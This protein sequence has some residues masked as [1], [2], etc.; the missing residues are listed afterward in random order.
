MSAYGRLD[1]V[2]EYIEHLIGMAED[3]DPYELGVL[4]C[5]QDVIEFKVKPDNRS[6]WPVPA[7]YV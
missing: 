7:E 5:L 1:Q 2:D 6:D 4:R 3:I